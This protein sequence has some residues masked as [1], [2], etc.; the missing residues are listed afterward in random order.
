MTTL[1]LLPIPAFD[2]LTSSP[3]V[4]AALLPAHRDLA[5]LKGLCTALPNPEILLDTLSIQ[6][7][8]DSSEIENIITTHDELYA[9]QVDSAV[10]IAAKEVQHYLSG[11]RTGYSQVK[12]SGIIRLETILSVQEEVEQNDAGL[13]QLPGTVLK[14]EVTGEVIYEPPQSAE[15]VARLMANLV[16]FIHADDELDSLVKMAIV[17]HQFES[18]HPFYD[19]NGRAGRILNIL[20]LVREGLLEIPILYLS[21]YINQTRQDYYRLLRVSRE[22]DRWEDWCVYIL[23]GISRTARS[24]IALIKQLRDLMEDFKKRLRDEFPKL[25]RQDLLNTL[26]RYPYTKIDFLEK[27]LGISRPT[28]TKYLKLL[29]GAGFLETRKIGRSHFYVNRELF[30]LLSTIQLPAV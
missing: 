29:T 26:F 14:N 12:T 1:P 28:A 20:M 17:H 4:W 8:K 19:G 24:E 13:R 2:R 23:H 15:D 30:R 10:G 18:I 3:A 27:E 5:E 7:A 11:L 16:D 9:S 22:E 21:R 25:Y 6:E